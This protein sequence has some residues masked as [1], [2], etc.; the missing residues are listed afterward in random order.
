MTKRVYNPATRENLY[1]LQTDYNYIKTKLLEVLYT[2]GYDEDYL[3]KISID[4]I[5]NTIRDLYPY[6]RTDEY[7]EFNTQ[8]EIILQQINILLALKARR[9]WFR[10]SLAKNNL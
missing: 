3:E 5:I 10:Y 1:S 6:V 9:I 7:T 4:D 8:S 2:I